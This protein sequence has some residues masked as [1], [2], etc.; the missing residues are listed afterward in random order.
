MLSGREIREMIADIINSIERIVPYAVE[1]SYDELMIG[2]NRLRL[3]IRS[4][5]GYLLRCEEGKMKPAPATVSVTGSRFIIKLESLF[6]FGIAYGSICMVLHQANLCE[7]LTR[8]DNHKA[9][10]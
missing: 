3:A 7:L 10:F 6:L 1:I 4:Q 8:F 9:P 2:R 5:S